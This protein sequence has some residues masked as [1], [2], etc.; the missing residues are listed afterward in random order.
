MIPRGIHPN[1]ETTHGQS[2]F[3]NHVRAHSYLELEISKSN[4]LEKKKINPLRMK[5]VDGSL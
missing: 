2:Y 3:K 4:E 5:Q 1:A